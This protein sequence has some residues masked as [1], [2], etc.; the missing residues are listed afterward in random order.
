MLA[1]DEGVDA[2]LGS[3][4]DSAL[5][6]DS[7]LP[8]QEGPWHRLWRITLKTSGLLLLARAD[9]TS[10]QERACSSAIPARNEGFLQL[11]KLQDGMGARAS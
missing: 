6:R 3:D 5:Q 1:G 2:S 11:V 7:E 9:R 10:S 4:V 8:E